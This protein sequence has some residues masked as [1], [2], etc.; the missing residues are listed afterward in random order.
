[1]AQARSMFQGH[2]DIFTKNS[3]LG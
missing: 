2:A 1:M 3:S